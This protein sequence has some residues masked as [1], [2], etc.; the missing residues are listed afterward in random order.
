MDP[1]IHFQMPSEDN[2]RVANFYAQA[3][4][5]ESKE[6][7]P[8]MGDYMLVNTTKSDER[9]WSLTPGAINGGF[10]KKVKPENG[11]GIVI[12]VDDIHESMKKVTEAG[13][14]VLG[15]MQSPTE[16]DDMPGVGFFVSILDTEGNNVGLMQRHK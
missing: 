6:L 10:Y 8:Q 15:G 11:T 1:V 16:P 13:G 14:K 5:W 7:G 12:E 9:D 2:K 3:F 4:G